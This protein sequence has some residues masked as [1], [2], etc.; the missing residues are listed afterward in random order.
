MNRTLMTLSLIAFTILWAGYAAAQDYT[1]G[2][3]RSDGTYVQG[4][5]RSSPNNTRLDNYSTRGN[6]NPYTGERGTRDPYKYQAPSPTYNS[7]PYDGIEW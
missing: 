7:D 6:I 5:Y 1:R 2:Y 4:Y 3:M